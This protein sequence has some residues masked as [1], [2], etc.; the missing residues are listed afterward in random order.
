VIIG[1]IALLGGG[2]SESSPPEESDRLNLTGEWGGTAEMHEWGSH[3]EAVMRLE[4]DPDL[5]HFF[6]ELEIYHPNGENEKRG[7][8]GEIDVSG[9][10][11]IFV[12]SA[13]WF[14]W[15]WL[16]GDI[17]GGELSLDCMHCEVHGGFE[18]RRR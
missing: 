15:G 3:R 13:N 6:G 16:E 14:Y 2:T 5:D 8:E 17:I 10:S 7:L 1:G 18:F 12:D 11:I 9:N 4:H